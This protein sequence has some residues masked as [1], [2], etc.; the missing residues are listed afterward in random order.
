[1]EKSLNKDFNFQRIESK[2]F[3]CK[4]FKVDTVSITYKTVEITH[5]FNS[6]LGKVLAIRPCKAEK[7]ASKQFHIYFTKHYPCCQ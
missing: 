7:G 1:M 2:S 5:G 4:L 3:I 6:F